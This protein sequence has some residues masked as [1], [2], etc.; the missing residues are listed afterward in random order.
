M[1]ADPL[2]GLVEAVA[3]VDVMT[4]NTGIANAGAAAVA[5]AVSVGVGGG[6]WRRPSI[7]RWLRQSSVRHTGVSSRG[8][9]SRRGSFGRARLVAAAGSDD[10]AVDAVATLVGTGWRPR[11]RCLRRWPWRS[12]SVPTRGGPAVR[13]PA[14]VATATPSPRWSGRCSGRVTG[15]PP[16][17]PP[18]GRLSRRRTRDWGLSWPSSRPGYLG[19]RGRC[20]CGGPR[21]SARCSGPGADPAGPRRQRHRRPHD[22][23]ACPAGARR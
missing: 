23:R 21:L 11:R 20:E 13:R 4:H 18:R 14:S 3:R 5:A 7:W 2:V 17:L 8:R 9:M 22:D 16:S 19:L 10:A 12:V 15:W 6:R 1:P